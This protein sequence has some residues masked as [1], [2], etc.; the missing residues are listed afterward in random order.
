MITRRFL[1]SFFVVLFL[2]FGVGSGSNVQASSGL[3]HQQIR[4]ARQAG[5]IKSLRWVVE[6]VKLQYPGRILD[7]ELSK[8]K[9][10]K[11]NENSSVYIYKIK[12]LQ[13]DGHI[14]KL[15]VHASTAEVLRAKGRHHRGKGKG[16]HKYK[17]RK[18]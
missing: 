11:C 2:T 5:D 13:D 3:S 12:L 14:I 1:F 7:A 9:C 10:N 17:N 16:R 18:D 8:N 4:E 6:Q 15:Y